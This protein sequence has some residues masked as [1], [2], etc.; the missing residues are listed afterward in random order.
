LFFK[1]GYGRFLGSDG[2]SLGRITAY[3]LTRGV[4]QKTDRY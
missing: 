2:K 1:V 4:R 3:D